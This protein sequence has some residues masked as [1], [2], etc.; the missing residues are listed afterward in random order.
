MV[1]FDEPGPIEKGWDVKQI[2]GA[3]VV[4]KNYL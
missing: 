3:S 4:K 1:D 2:A